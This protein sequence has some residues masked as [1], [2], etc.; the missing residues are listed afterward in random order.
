MNADQAAAVLS[1][2]CQGKAR[3][4]AKNARQAAARL[5]A[6]GEDVH[7]YRCNVCSWWH[8]GH[9]PSMD[10]IEAIAAAI[11]HRNYPEA[12]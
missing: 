9:T 10:T 4:N 7:P 11:R 2:M 12:S 6:K 5:Q 8:I 1:R 3:R